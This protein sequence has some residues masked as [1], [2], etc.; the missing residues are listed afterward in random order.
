LEIISRLEVL[1][2]SLAVSIITIS[3]LH[4][5]NDI[6]FAMGDNPSICVNLYNS[7]ITSMKIY[8]TDNVRKQILDPVSNPKISFDSILGHG[9]NVT[10]TLH[11]ASRNNQHNTNAG[12]VWFDTSVNGYHQGRCVNGAS[13]NSYMTI[14]ENNLFPTT[15][16]GGTMHTPVQWY[17]SPFSAPFLTY[18]V[19]WHG[20]NSY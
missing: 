12:S 19:T 11:V 2:L 8:N 20:Q 7:T 15:L 1:V 9:Y 10:F 3:V 13:A 4:T 18:T 6:A 17:S 16:T 14:K 5:N